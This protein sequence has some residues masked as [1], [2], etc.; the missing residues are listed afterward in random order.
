[1]AVSEQRE[2]DDLLDLYTRAM[3]KPLGPFFHQL[4]QDVAALHLKWNE[5]L[6][7]S[8]RIKRASTT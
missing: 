4:W 5:Y 7:C 3:G 1:M 6:P 2:P 8:G